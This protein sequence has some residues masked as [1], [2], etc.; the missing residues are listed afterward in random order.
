MASLPVASL[1][2]TAHPCARAFPAAMV[3]STVVKG[4]TLVLCA[5]ASMTLGF[6][7]QDE[8]IRATEVRARARLVETHLGA[9]SEHCHSCRSCCRSEW[10]NVSTPLRIASSGGGEKRRWRQ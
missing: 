7:V 1:T 8:M 6:Y 4:T 5:I 2:P 10:R 9:V 3:S